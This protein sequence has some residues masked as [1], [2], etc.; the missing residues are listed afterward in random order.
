MEQPPVPL[1]RRKQQIL[2]AVVADYTETGVPVGSNSLEP[3]HALLIL[4]LEGNLIRQQP[5][6]LSQEAAQETLSALAAQLNVEF[7]GLD[8]VAVDAQRAGSAAPVEATAAG[9][10]RDELL[11]HILTF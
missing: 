5:V 11:D 9:T 4:V 3:R 7:K 6:E 10:L 2:K 1:D 8:S